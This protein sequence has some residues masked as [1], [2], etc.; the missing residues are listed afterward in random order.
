MEAPGPKAATKGDPGQNTAGPGFGSDF[1][2][3]AAQKFLSIFF[4]PVFGTKIH[5]LKSFK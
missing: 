5:R 3:V 1:Y 4:C 2:N